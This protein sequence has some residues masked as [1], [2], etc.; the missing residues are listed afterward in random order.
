MA[1]QLAQLNVALMLEPLESPRFAEFVHNLDRINALAEAA[2]GFVWR[3]QT[4][5][6]DA[7]SLRPV[8]DDV[9]VNLS[10]WRDVVSLKAFVYNGDH[11]AIMKKRKEWFEHMRQA[12]SVLWWVPENERP[13]VDQALERL[14]MLRVRGPS[15]DAFTFANPFDPP[16]LG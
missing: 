5:D 12:H 7:T 9:L 14:E 16:S 3:L 4:D 8:G 2:S 11:L 10:V 15:V 1:W 13:D 6:G